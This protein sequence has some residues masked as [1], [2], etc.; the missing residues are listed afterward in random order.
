MRVLSLLM[1]VILAS[2]GQADPK[3]QLEFLDGYWE[4]EKVKLASG[5]EKEFSISTQID[6][7]EVTGDS[8]VRK[9]VRPRFDG[10]Y[11]VTKS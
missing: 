4:I 3:V 5:E 11:A 7:I 1:F 2:C 10:T 6:F 8:G 9:K